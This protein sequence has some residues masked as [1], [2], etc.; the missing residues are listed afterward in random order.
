VRRF[1]LIFCA[2]V[3]YLNQCLCIFS[4]HVRNGATVYRLNWGGDSSAKGFAQSLSVMANYRYELN[5]LQHNHQ[6]YVEHGRVP[7]SAE[8]AKLAQ[9]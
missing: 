1:I 9:C 6:Q 4:F 3:L 5:Q 8:V 2:N 7:M